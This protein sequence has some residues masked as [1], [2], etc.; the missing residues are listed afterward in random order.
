MCKRVLPLEGDPVWS[1]TKTNGPTFLRG[2]LPPFFFAGRLKNNMDPEANM[3]K[4]PDMLI[5]ASNVCAPCCATETIR[6]F[7]CLMFCA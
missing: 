1:R 7:L 2:S 5:N 4:P 6:S 3:E